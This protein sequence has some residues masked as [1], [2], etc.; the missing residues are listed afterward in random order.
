MVRRAKIDGADNHE[1]MAVELAD[2][3]DVDSIAMAL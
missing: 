1:Q 3:D 2:Q